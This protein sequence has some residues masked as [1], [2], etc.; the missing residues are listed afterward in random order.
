MT[1]LKRKKNN[2][3]FLQ[4]NTTMENVKIWFLVKFPPLLL[5]YHD[6]TSTKNEVIPLITKCERLDKG[7][8]QLYKL[9]KKK[10]LNNFV[11]TSLTLARW[12]MPHNNVFCLNIFIDI[13]FIYLIKSWKWLASQSLSSLHLKFDPHWVFYF[14]DFFYQVKSQGWIINLS[15]SRHQFSTYEFRYA[16][17]I[18]DSNKF[19]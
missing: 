17:R 2:F 13:R 4:S 14:Y 10:K 8:Q 3:F 1:S 18:L 19:F 16:I 7:L 6:F 11:P 15:P 12:A 9:K 5:E